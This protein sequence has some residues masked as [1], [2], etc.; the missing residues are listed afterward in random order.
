MIERGLYYAKTSFATLIKN[1]GGQWNDTK[2]RPIVCL[3]KCK[4]NDKIYWAI[5]MGKYNHRTKEQIKRINFFINLPDSDIRS[6][7]Y[8]IGK[9]TTKSIFFISDVIPITDEYIDCVH[10]GPNNLHYVIKN[11]NLLKELE[12]KMRRIIYDEN[13]N[14]NKYRQHITAVKEKLKNSL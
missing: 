1:A 12:R 14:P 9:T 13:R 3:V 4:E 5:P 11:P 2:H 6:C 8:H 7:Y 10:T